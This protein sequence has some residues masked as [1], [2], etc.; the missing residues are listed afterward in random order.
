MR[1]FFYRHDVE[2]GAVDPR[3][4]PYY[5]LLVGGPDEVPFS[6]QYDLDVRYAVGRLDFDSPQEYAAYAESV[7]AAEKAGT[8]S[9]PRAERRMTFFC[10]DNSDDASLRI[11]EELVGGLVSRFSAVRQPDWNVQSVLDDDATQESL[12]DL[13]EGDGMPDVLFTACHGLTFPSGHPLQREKQG[14][15]HCKSRAGAAPLESSVSATEISDQARV[16][17]LI[18]FN[19]ACYSA[20]NPGLELED[21]EPKESVRRANRPFTARLPQR[22]LGHPNGGALAVVGHVSRAWTYSFSGFG[23][24]PQLN[25]F[26]DV[27]RRILRGG[28]VGHALELFNLSYAEKAAELM[29]LRELDQLAPS[30]GQREGQL[31]LA[32]CI[33]KDA[34]NYVVLG[35]PAVRLESP[36]APGATL[37]TPPSQEN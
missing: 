19:F 32:Y 2:F 26:E 28:R 21:L 37:T 13:L 7:V 6:F 9:S 12:C 33:A 15:L 17:G 5:L 14:A 1:D 36:V 4:M 30:N 24:A 3:R 16:H 35:D 23:K 31:A 20:G 22:L 27:I 29:N 34:R 10:P 11:R 18:A 8:G 25:T